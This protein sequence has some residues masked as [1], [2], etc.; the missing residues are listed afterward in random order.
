M[1]CAPGPPGAAEERLQRVTAE[2]I[3]KVCW[4]HCRRAPPRRPA[5][6][7]PHTAAPAPGNLAAR[8]TAYAHATA[9]TAQPAH[10]RTQKHAFAQKTLQDERFTIAGGRSFERQYAQLYYSRLM[11]LEP[12]VAARARAAWPDVPSA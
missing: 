10:A 12:A 3:V 1:L 4:R 2:C 5:A 6:R 11:A 9:H 8:A 7:R